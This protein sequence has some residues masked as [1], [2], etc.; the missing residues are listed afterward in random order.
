MDVVAC[1]VTRQSATPSSDDGG[2]AAVSYSDVGGDDHSATDADDRINVVEFVD[3]VATP[4][5]APPRTVNGWWFEGGVW[6]PRWSHSSGGWWLHSDLL[7]LASS[8]FLVPATAVRMLLTDLVVMGSVTVC[9]PSTTDG[10]GRDGRSSEVLV[11]ACLPWLSRVAVGCGGGGAVPPPLTVE[12]RDVGAVTTSEEQ[13]RSLLWTALA[14]DARALDAALDCVVG[15]LMQC[16]VLSRLLS[17]RATP[18]LRLLL[19]RLPAASAVLP[20][21]TSTAG[22]LVRIDAAA[23]RSGLSAASASH[24]A[25]VSL[26]ASPQ[27]LVRTVLAEAVIEGAGWPGACRVAVGDQLVELDTSAA[28]VRLLLYPAGS[29]DVCGWIVSTDSDGADVTRRLFHAVVDACKRVLSSWQHVVSVGSFSVSSAPAQQPSAAP[30]NSTSAHLGVVKRDD[31]QELDR[32][33]VADLAVARIDALELRVD[34]L[35]AVMRPDREQGRHEGVVTAISI[36]RR[37]KAD[38]SD[39][40]RLSSQVELHDAAV[41]HLRADIS[42]RLDRLE[43]V[44]LSDVIP[45]LD[46]VE[47]AVAA[48]VACVSR[49]SPRRCVPHRDVPHVFKSDLHGAAVHDIV[50]QLTARGT[51]SGDGGSGDG[52]AV[53]VSVAATGMGGVGKT[54][55][56]LQAFEHA[57]VV[58]AFGRRRYWLTLGESPDVLSLVNPLLSDLAVDLTAAG[59]ALGDAVTSVSSMGEASKALDGLLRLMTT[60]GVRVLLVLDDVWRADH[61]RPFLL[62]LHATLGEHWRRVCGLSYLLT[63]RQSAL[64]R[65]QLGAVVRELGVVSGDA[66]LDLF[67]R[68]CGVDVGDAGR[69][70]HDAAA[71]RICSR[72]C[73]G[74]ALALQIVGGVVRSKLDVGDALADTFAMLEEE[75]PSSV[76]LAPEDVDAFGCGGVVDPVAQ[77]GSMRE[78]V[79]LSLRSVGEG[80]RRRYLQLAVFG[81][82]VVISSDVLAV[83]WGVSD[84]V[85]KSECHMLVD[86]HLLLRAESAAGVDA[87]HV[88]LHDLQ[89]DVLVRE[90]GDVG[91][92]AMHG[93]LLWSLAKR[94]CGVSDMAT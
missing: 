12:G 4:A 49:P 22:Q 89:R 64:L 19:P 57:D 60:G 90:A 3:S 18:R 58:C 83:L 48:A 10:D 88:M 69:R 29:I 9:R 39:V 86:R 61:A 23:S 40:R 84:T 13:L 71:R 15:Y 36:L 2:D 70:S 30:D 43:T 5:T 21:R 74:V 24:I 77:Y 52:V 53:G 42:P 16:G 82:D 37:S 26:G 28:R 14:C 35:R 51:G 73:G 68:C 17:R 72:V 50:A 33:A 41:Q 54:V 66:S 87:V 63:S 56:A 62:H 44:A 25:H 79:L 6:S 34:E 31:T 45:R 65:R 38:A 80:L 75:V 1:A 85:A 32:R 59:V 47:A 20:P 76:S 81:E 7:R 91:L 8:L 11:T 92:S 78:C 55:L 67:W 46:R 27:D 94:C 93:S